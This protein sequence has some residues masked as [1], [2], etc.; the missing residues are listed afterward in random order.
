GE[1]HF[2]DDD[3]LDLPEY[4]RQMRSFSGVPTSA[5]PSPERYRDGFLTA[6]KAFGIT[7]SGNLSGSYASAMVG[8]N[9]AEEQGADVHVF[10]SKSASAGEILVAIKTRA[11]IALGKTKEEIVASVEAFIKRMKTFF[12]LEDLENLIKNGR[13]SKIKGRIISALNIRPLLGSDGDGNI[14]LYSI[15]RGEK[16]SIEKMARTVA[17]SEVQTEGQT[18]VITH[19][20]NESFAMRLKKL[21][22]ERYSFAE[23]LVVPTKGL[24]SMYANEKGVI[25]AF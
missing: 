22:E 20:N 13:M 6:E 21:L 1:Q 23:V 7:L 2:I 25:L 17:E 14:A 5:A 24:S 3:T 15:A 4:M 9:L 18:A 8:K 16:Q 11:L 19:C 12:V 10:D